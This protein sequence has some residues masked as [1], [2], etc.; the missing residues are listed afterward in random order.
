MMQ[1]FSIANQNDL[2]Q[3]QE[4]AAREAEEARR[5]ATEGETRLTQRGDEMW[6]GFR[7]EPEVR[8]YQKAQRLYG[9][10]QMA[11]QAEGGVSDLDLI[12]AVGNILDPESV[13]R[14]GETV[15]VQRSG[16]LV[17]QIRGFIDRVSGGQG[18]TPEMRVQLRQLAERRMSAYWDAVDPIMGA[19]RER[20]RATGLNPD[21]ILLGV[22]SPDQIRQRTTRTREGASQSLTGLPPVAPSG[23]GG[24]AA[25]AAPAAA[26]AAPLV[27]GRDVVPP[28]AQPGASVPIPQRIQGLQGISLSRAIEAMTD[29]ELRQMERMTEVDP[30]ARQGAAIVLAQRA[31]RAR[32]ERR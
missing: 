1:A 10:L 24:P 28:P 22:E 31:E 18:L 26:P 21:Q 25:P 15:M 17:E 23:Q 27:P 30:I 6:R 7:A 2:R 5:R 4:T 20:A 32:R 9:S 8:N 14:E 13:V 16:G 11:A 3:R 12:Y 19:Y 29:A